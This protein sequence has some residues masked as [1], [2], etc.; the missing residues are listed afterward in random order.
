MLL[1][2]RETPLRTHPEEY[3]FHTSIA[4]TAEN[5]IINKTVVRYARGLRRGGAGYIYELREG[6]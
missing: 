2:S 4:C 1:T 5:R 6:R 3:R